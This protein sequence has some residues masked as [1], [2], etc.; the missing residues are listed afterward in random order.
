MRRLDT[1]SALVEL[2]VVVSIIGLLVGMALPPVGRMYRNQSN[3]VMPVAPQGVYVGGMRTR[4]P[5]RQA[6]PKSRPDWR[7]C[8]SGRV[9][10]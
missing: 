3:D 6:W 8:W 7:R 1:A 4:T 5:K 2:L 9:E 10:A